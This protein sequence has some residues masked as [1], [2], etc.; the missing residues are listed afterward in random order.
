MPRP[1]D[2]FYQ[3]GALPETRK[4]AVTMHGPAN[5]WTKLQM[6][7]DEKSGAAKT[8]LAMDVPH[9]VVVNTCTRGPNGTSEALVFL[10][11]V[12]VMR[13]TTTKLGRLV[14]AV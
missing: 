4:P 12:K 2:K 1:N 7:R 5:L 6:I 3:R 14:A 11:G 9:G 8:T 13:D 10:P